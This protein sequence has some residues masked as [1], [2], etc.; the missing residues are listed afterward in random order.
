MGALDVLDVAGVAATDP[1]HAMAAKANIANVSPKNR[2]RQFMFKVPIR[3]NP[4]KKNLT[5]EVR[6]LQRRSDSHPLLRSASSHALGRSPGS[7]FR[8]VP[9][10]FRS[11]LSG[12]VAIFLGVDHTSYSGATAPVSHRLPFSVPI[13]RDHLW[14]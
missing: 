14:T 2:A 12:T 1:P 5:S 13:P 7:W 8:S 3:F 11:L 10:A 6:L 4:G 9:L